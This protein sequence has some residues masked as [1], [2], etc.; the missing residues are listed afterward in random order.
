MCQFSAP[1]LGLSLDL[2]TQW[3]LSFCSVSRPFLSMFDHL[4]HSPTIKTFKSYTSMVCLHLAYVQH[5]PV[6]PLNNLN[7]GSRTQNIAP[8]PQW[9]RRTGAEAADDASVSSDSTSH[10]SI[11]CN[12]RLWLAAASSA[13][14]IH[15]CCSAAGA[16]WARALIHLSKLPNFISR[17]F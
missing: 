17:C 1:V 14:L 6:T 4:K 15:L 10:W 3:F 13:R 5:L 12:E 2:K 16:E 7:S 8:R 11:V 9:W